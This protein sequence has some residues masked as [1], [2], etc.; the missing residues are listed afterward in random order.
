MRGLITFGFIREEVIDLG[1]CAIIGNDCEPFVIHVK[2]K[3]LALE[4]R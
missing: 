3:I 2:N 1:G 4:S